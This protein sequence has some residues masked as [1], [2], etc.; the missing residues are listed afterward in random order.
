MTEDQIKHM[1]DQFLRWKLPEMDPPE[2]ERAV[3]SLAS[4]LPPG[5][6]HD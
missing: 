6:S 5:V 4:S 1:V 3:I 2:K